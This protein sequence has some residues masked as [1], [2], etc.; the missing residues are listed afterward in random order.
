MSRREEME[1]ALAALLQVELP[2]GPDFHYNNSFGAFRES[3]GA[4]QAEV[5]RLLLQVQGR[6]GTQQVDADEL[7]DREDGASALGEMV[8]GL[9][10]DLLEKVDTSLD[11]ARAQLK[12]QPSSAPAAGAAAAGASA[13][14]ASLVAG[15]NAAGDKR[16]RSAFAAA[17]TDVSFGPRPQDSFKPPVDNSNAPFRPRLNHWA[18]FQEWE[19][20]QESN[21]LNV[22]AQR[23]GVA[24]AGSQAGVHPLEG[25]LESLTYQ[26]W[27][28]EALE[29]LLP[30]GLDE[31][32]LTYVDTPEGLHSLTAALSAVRE[33]AVDLEAHSYRSFQG[34]CC[35]M[36]LSTRT[37]DYLV[38]VI[39]L[40]SIVGSVL[41]PIFADVKIVK[42]LHG[43]DSDIVWL[44]RDFGIYVANLF[45]TGQAARVLAYPSAGLAYLLS[46]FCSVKAD[47]RWQL[48]DW[49]VRPLSA[50]ALHYARMDT[51]YL[52][53]IYDC[54]K[55]EL[56]KVPRVPDHLQNEVPQRGPKS[57]LGVVLERSRLLCLQ[58]YEKELFSESAYLDYYRR[59][60]ERLTREQ[61]AVFAG[62]Y[63]WR[64]RT[65]RQRDESVGFV[66]PKSQILK[67]AKRAP[68]SV[69]DLRAVLG[70]QGR[71]SSPLLVELAGEVVE[72]IQNSR[73]QVD[74]V[75]DPDEL[76]G[77]SA[78]RPSAAAVA[79]LAERNAA[80]EEAF[81]AAA[82]AA[83]R[84]RAGV[85]DTADDA[86]P[87]AMEEDDI[88]AADV[89]PEEGVLEGQ[90]DTGETA[91]VAEASAGHGG[92]VLGGARESSQGR[93]ESASAPVARPVDPEHSP[94]MPQQAPPLIPKQLP[95]LVPKQLQPFG[96]APKSGSAVSAMLGAGPARPS[97]L[98][99]L[100]GGRPQP[101]AAPAA[102]RPPANASV[103][104]QEAHVSLPAAVHNPAGSVPEPAGA[105]SGAVSVEASMAFGAGSGGAAQLAGSFGR[106]SSGLGAAFGAHSGR[107]SSGLGALLGG[108]KATA[109][110]SAT[111]SLA[112]VQDT[113]ATGSAS[114]A[115]KLAV[116]QLKA[117]FALPFALPRAGAP[118]D[119]QALASESAAQEDSAMPKAPAADDEEAAETA[120]ERR[121]A[122]AAAVR[123]VMEQLH[124]ENRFGALH[125]DTAAAAAQSSRPSSRGAAQ[126][127]EPE[128]AEEDFLPLP[129]SEQYKLPGKK[130]RRITAQAV[131]PAEPRG[132]IREHAPAHGMEQAPSVE[133][134][135]A[136]DA[137]GMSP[138]VRERLR[139]AADIRATLKAVGLDDED[140]AVGLMSNSKK[141][142]KKKK[143]LDV[144]AAS[145]MVGGAGKD[146][147]HFKKK[148][149][150]G[151]K[152]DQTPTQGNAGE[153]AAAAAAVAAGPAVIPFDFAAARESAKGLDVSGGIGGRGGMPRGPKGA[154]S[155]GRGGRGRGGE[156]EKGAQR[157]GFNPWDSIQEEAI[158]G[159]KRSAVM[160]RSGNR[161]MT[162][163]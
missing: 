60:H 128:Q 152:L 37:A 126:E 16:A 99:A 89:E 162:F 87:V 58:R 112:A 50:E 160:P 45:D 48:A 65:A 4:L 117:N 118:A 157:K 82:A 67:L 44:Q 3:A 57:C 100:F 75:P 114:N 73:Q 77:D 11:R 132:P 81:S 10:D 86:G 90:L 6:F 83:P 139:C 124:S 121:A 107:S 43:A 145:E 69:H 92:R 147:P 142:K 61:L 103:E 105:A 111:S 68:S 26:E 130:K 46:H 17:H 94:V 98:G 109:V 150:Q 133:Q 51:H 163:G 122:Q 49:R 56:A 131:Q 23:L 31:T 14:G 29:P 19:G 91:A 88:S 30:Q 70:I 85:D 41:A 119:P 148:R 1:A 155:V 143:K 18:G 38:D 137:A 123:D 63:A 134:P 74:G 144:T 158:K 161:S 8:E 125:S 59:C 96:G 66:L 138:E 21:A 20:R 115:A 40:R 113:P 9:L 101:S 64:D 32:P 53:Y 106:P 55:V 47:K 116:E 102:P 141:Q 79:A 93:K 34:F 52:L 62:L 42:V 24:A 151:A 22:H 108:R 72:V 80:V 110:V 104:V 27:Q 36:Q 28:L 136:A 54:L 129:I 153:D 154:R 156:K 140:V 135:E 78:R 39:A 35:L 146:E 76:P 33:I 71:R 7:R 127:V 12:A 97:A 25:V 120:E 84:G 95:P 5:R 2:S 13:P 159:G 15:S 149:K